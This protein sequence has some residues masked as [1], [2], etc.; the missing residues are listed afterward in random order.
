[1]HSHHQP[2]ENHDDQTLKETTRFLQKFFKQPDI[3]P[4]PDGS[5]ETKVVLLA[6]NARIA[7]LNTQRIF[8]K[9]SVAMA[10]TCIQLKMQ[11]ADDQLHGLKPL[12]YYQAKKAF[13]E[14]DKRNL[15]SDIHKL[16]VAAAVLK[17]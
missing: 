11:K 6:I 1:M 14:R 9:N 5:S 7:E 13:F 8:A 4:K 3:N 16:E 2:E 12:D 10:E 15:E 17:K